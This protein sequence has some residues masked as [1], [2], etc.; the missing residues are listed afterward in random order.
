[1]KMGVN[2]NTYIG[3]D[4]LGNWYAKVKITGCQNEEQAEKL[5]LWAHD[6]VIKKFDE[7]NAANVAKK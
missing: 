4:D 3:Q 5:A 6:A 7:I 1:M 2:T